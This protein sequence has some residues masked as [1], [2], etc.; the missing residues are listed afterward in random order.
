M[1]E[2]VAVPKIVFEILHPRLSKSCR[3]SGWVESNK[4]R[5]VYLLQFVQTIQSEFRN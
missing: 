4:N 3:G 5:E 2:T 1:S